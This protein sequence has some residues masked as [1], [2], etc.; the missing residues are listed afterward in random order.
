[1]GQQGKPDMELIC[2]SM[3]YCQTNFELLLQTEY[4]DEE[5]ML[6]CTGQ[7]VNGLSYLHGK[8]GFTSHRDLTEIEALGY[9]EMMHH[10]LKPDNVLVKTHKEGDRLR[11]VL[12]IADFGL[13]RPSGGST[14]VR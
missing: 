3:D 1:M 10:D 9:K 4:Q 13:T 11:Q 8:R 7:M 12:K 14:N 2:I 5:K 6:N